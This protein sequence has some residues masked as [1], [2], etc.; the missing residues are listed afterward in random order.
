[1][2]REGGR[3]KQKKPFAVMDLAEQC[4]L[5]KLSGYPL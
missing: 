1:M 5:T 4:A 2:E 3:R